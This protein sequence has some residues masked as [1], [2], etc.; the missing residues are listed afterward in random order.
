LADELQRVV[1]LNRLISRSA[2]RARSA[3]APLHT[4]HHLF[5][6]LKGRFHAG[7]AIE[8]LR[9]VDNVDEAER[10]RLG[11][12]SSYTR[13]ADFQYYDTPSY[14]YVM[15]LVKHVNVA[16]KAF[17]VE[18]RA[19]LEGREVSGEVNESGAIAAHFVARLPLAESL[20]DLGNYRCLTEVAS[21]ITRSHLEFLLCRQLRRT[22]DMANWTFSST[23]QAKRSAKPMT[24]DH[25]YTPRLEFGGDIGRNMS[26]NGSVR[27]IS[28]MVF[29]KEAERETIGPGLE[30]D[31]TD[32]I[33]NVEIRIAA[34]QAPE[35]PEEKVSWFER[36]KKHFAGQGYE[37]RLH[38]KH[39]NG[40]YVGG[41]VHEAVDGAFDIV[42]C[43]REIVQLDK[44]LLASSSTIDADFC[45]KLR[46]V[47]DK[48]EL[49]TRGK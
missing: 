48:D 15:M 10:K 44:P 34:S 13:I 42:M 35:K 30:V 37:V 22:T 17:S 16:V 7:L 21:P 18:N 9:A 49:W 6:I 27:E 31:R 41:E 3:T 45:S 4:A 25:P 46:D 28:S 43:D 12:Q 32:V 5:E 39:V 1:L 36:V 40:G 26:T 29:L 33:K 8:Y 2:T 47:L 38:F 11:A 24:K 19:N 14:R 20:L 23:T